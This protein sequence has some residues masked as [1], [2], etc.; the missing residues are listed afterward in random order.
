MATVDNPKVWG[1][2]DPELPLPT[3]DELE[4]IRE[5]IASSSGGNFLVA[6]E[7]AEFASG[8]LLVDP[9]SATI[10]LVKDLPNNITGMYDETLKMVQEDTEHLPFVKQLL[11]LAAF[12]KELVKQE[13]L[14]TAIPIGMVR[15]RVSGGLLSKEGAGESQEIDWKYKILSRE[16]GS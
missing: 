2:R 6:K 3:D 14:Y 7:K 8:S 1:S 5:T 9:Q 12:Q 10:A 13:E 15:D 11:Q 4:E 16:T